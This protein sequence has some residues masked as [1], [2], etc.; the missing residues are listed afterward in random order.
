[1]AKSKKHK[2]ELNEPA[3]EH[4]REIH[5]FNSFKE[6]EDYELKQMAM[7]SSIEILQQLRKFINIAYG[8]HGYDPNKL[9]KKHTIK[10]I[11]NK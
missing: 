3:V 10:I 9:P 7:L 8:M 1:M 5:V 6:Q 11:E 2:N 4:G